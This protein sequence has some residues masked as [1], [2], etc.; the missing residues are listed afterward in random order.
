VTERE[1]IRVLWLIKGLGPGGAERLLVEHARAGDRDRFAYEAAY[2]LDWKRHLVPELEELGVRTRCLGASSELDPR[3]T[4][5]LAT[6][7]RHE[8]YDIVHAHSPTVASVGRVEARALPRSR[9]PAF[10]YTEHNRWPSYRAETRVANQLTFGLNDAAFAV[11]DD[12]RDS[13]S[14]RFRGDIEVVVHG[15][16]VDDVRAHRAERATVRSELGVVSGESLAVTVANLR[17]GKN[18]PGLI[19]A[20]RLVSDRGV[21]VR[22]ATAGQGQLQAEVAEL[23]R[24]SGLGHRFALLGYRD[25]TTRLIAGARFAP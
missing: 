7:L 25:D 24:R 6:L 10:V 20:A 2:V 12:V 16:N 23:Q 5:R 9:R 22:F 14:A 3:W 4:T 19:D 8:H 15:V 11:S 21:P 17:A 13:V 18:Y 1:R